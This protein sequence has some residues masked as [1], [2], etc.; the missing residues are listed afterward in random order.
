MEKNGTPA[1]PA[2]LRRT[3]LGGLAG[4]YRDNCGALMSCLTI[5]P[6]ESAEIRFFLGE[7]DTFDQAR[8]VVERYRRPEVLEA[9]LARVKEFWDGVLD[10]LVVS[11]PDPLFDAMANGRA[12]Y[13]ALACRLWGRTAL[14][15]SSGAYGFR[16]QLQDV[17]ALTLARPDLARAHI[18]EAS[19]HQFAE[20]DALHWWQPYSGRGVRTR[21]KDDRLWLPYTVADYVFSTGDTSILDEEV[22]FIMGPPVPEDRED[23]YLVPQESSETATLYEHCL[24]AFDVSRD[25]GEHGL[26]LI[27]GGDWNDG[28]NRVGHEGRGES[29]WLAWFLVTGL[30]R[31]AP[32]CEQ[33][34][35]GGRAE[36]LRAWADRLVAAVEREAWDGAWY[37]RAY[38]DDGTPLGTRTADECRIDAVAQAWAV[39]SG[40]GD[41]QRARTALDSVE[42]KLVRREAG[43]IA[44]LT[45]PFDHMEHDPGYIKGYVPGV[46]ENGGQYTHAALWVVMAYALMGDGD[47]AVG[48]LDL[49]N[50]FAHARTRG[51]ADIYRVE[52]YTVVADVYAVRPH[53]GRGGWSW[54]TG[55]AALFH[56]TAIQSILGIRTS[57]GAG[58][59]ILTVDPTI[60][61]AWPGFEAT[62][63]L[64]STTWRIRVDNPR[65]ANR[66]VER[67]T[68][69]GAPVPDGHIPLTDDGSDHSVVIYML[70][71]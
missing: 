21:F 55:S 63:R 49:L 5:D 16:D 70:G 3:G 12:L 47:K 22:P 54:Y 58:G 59:R 7:C 61:K 4:R 29:V 1:S 25:V 14:Y 37:R 35:D 46:R 26:P 18:L 36:D 43:L 20:G 15:Q 65:G 30:R 41:P 68:L 39:I 53:V 67:T 71:G 57:G 34:G 44:L 66:G 32:I 48:L 8:Q 42:E 19:R 13:Q 2:A 9:E 60:P 51:D 28:M 31:F 11:T 62:L 50:P 69:D 38:F 52:P 23:L 6:G 45:P 33:R 27:G 24:R 64:G 56:N 10:T 17:S 40:A